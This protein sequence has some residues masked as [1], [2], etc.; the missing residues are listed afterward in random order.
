MVRR[1]PKRM[2]AP[3]PKLPAKVDWGKYGAA[4]RAL[5]E[6]HRRFALALATDPATMT[7][8]TYGAFTRAARAAGYKESNAANLGKMAYQLAHDDRIKLAVQELA[9]TRIELAAP[10]V[11]EKYI[12]L[13]QNE[14]ARDHGRAVM[15]GVDRLVPITT[16]QKIDVT[17][18]LI[19][20]DQEALEELRALRQLGVSREKMIETFGENALPRIERL[21]AA[22]NASRAEQAK[23][24]SGDY[25]IING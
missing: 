17:H 4:M 15:A 20:P 21:E 18:R 3:P 25:E 6:Q 23:V 11:A 1:A 19:D 5:S 13:L 24:I 12:A 16:T 9:R 22:D 7:G 14:S 2:L 10:L 8:Q